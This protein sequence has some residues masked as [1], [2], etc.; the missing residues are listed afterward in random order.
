MLI[1]SIGLILV[2]FQSNWLSSSFINQHTWSKSFFYCRI[3]SSASSQ[4]SSSSRQARFF[5]R[6]L[7]D[8]M[9]NRP[10]QYEIPNCYC[11]IPVQVKTSYTSRHPCRRFGICATN[12]CNC[13]TLVD[14][15]EVPSY[16]HDSMNILIRKYEELS[17]ENENL[18]SRI[19]GEENGS[20]KKYIQEKGFVLGIYVGFMMSIFLVIISKY[21]F[22]VWTL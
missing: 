4:Q 18:R 14:H 20:W 8:A 16:A 19:H 6:R 15:G 7:Y 13:W 22:L 5:D 11:G 9:W 2:S 3:M 10:P 17:I 1:H 12:T 21:M